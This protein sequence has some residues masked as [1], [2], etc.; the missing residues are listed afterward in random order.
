ML[1]FNPERLGHVCLLADEDWDRLK[2]LVIPVSISFDY[3]L[4][5]PNNFKSSKK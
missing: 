3:L 4:N 1:D 5:H 2:S